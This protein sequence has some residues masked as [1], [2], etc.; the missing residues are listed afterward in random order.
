M[1]TKYI[2]FDNFGV[3]SSRGRPKGSTKT[4]EPLPPNKC[5][6]CH[7][8]NDRDNRTLCTA[9]TK[10]MNEIQKE[11]RNQARLTKAL[12]E[13]IVKYLGDGDF[14]GI[15]KEIEHNGVKR[16]VFIEMFITDSEGRKPGDDGY[17]ESD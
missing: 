3:K 4:K 6:R 10:Y 8:E 11:K 7:K 13:I 16:L 17:G 15:S 5:K 9:C 12:D 1:E 2:P 14:I